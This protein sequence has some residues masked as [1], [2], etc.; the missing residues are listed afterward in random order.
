MTANMP[1]QKEASITF[2]PVIEAKAAEQPAPT[3]TFAP[4]IQPSEV[5]NQ[6]NISVEPTP[7]TVENNTTV[8]PAEVKVDM[9]KPKR[10]RQKVKRNKQTG[11]IESTDTTIEYE[12]K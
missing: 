8:Q 11:L 7:L 4:V 3:V 5:I 1:E 10:E 2:A 12:D 6:N 9:P